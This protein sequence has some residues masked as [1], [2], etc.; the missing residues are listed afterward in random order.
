MRYILVLSAAIAMSF[1]TSASGQDDVGPFGADAESLLV[2]TTPEHLAYLFEQRDQAVGQSQVFAGERTW[3]PGDTLKVCFFGG[4]PV[5]RALIAGVAVE[6]SAYANIQFDFGSPNDRRDC[7]SA[8]SGFSQIKIGFGEKGYWSA[9][10]TDSVELLNAYQPSMNLEEFD[11]RYSP[12]QPAKGGGLLKP[13]NVLASA[14]ARDRATILHEFGHALG[15][16]HEHQNP[17]LGCQD[18]I[19]WSGENNVYDYYARPPNRWD[20]E[21]VDR[22]LGPIARTDPDAVRGAPDRA[23]IMIYAQPARIFLRG[24]A[25]SCFVPEPT[26]ISAADKAII[27]KMY[28]VGAVPPSDTEFTSASLSAPLSVPLALPIASTDRLERIRADLSSPLS[29][30]RREARRQ[31]AIELSRSSSTVWTDLAAQVAASGDYRQQLGMVVAID[32]TT[33]APALDADQ[34]ESLRADLAKIRAGTRDP[35]L[36]SATDSALNRLGMR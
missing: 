8:S 27:A 6:W 29:S 13:E 14:S 19:R 4:N 34:V 33:T 16:L 31:L 22:N 11:F 23:S 3:E 28:P 26:A 5:V 2:E 1:A 9:V 18:E 15:L 12:Y 30:A 7:R 36:Q 17:A 24:A 21:K 10:G 32:R 25:S 35:T 20:R